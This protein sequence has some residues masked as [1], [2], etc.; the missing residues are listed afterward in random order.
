MLDLERVI[1]DALAIC[2]APS[3]TGSEQARA[4]L[5]TARLAATPGVFPEGDAHGNVLAPIKGTRG[6]GPPVVVAAHL[7][8][9]FGAEVTPRPARSGNRLVGPGIGDNSLALAA[10]LALAAD[11]RTAPPE[12]DVLLVA[13]VGEEGLGNLR[14]IRGLLADR[15]ARFVVALEGHGVDDLV[16]GAVGSTRLE[17][18]CE[19]PGGHS[20]HNRS[21]P[22]AVHELARAVSGLAYGLPPAVPGIAVNIGT[23]SGGTGINVI[24][25]RS[26]FQLDLRAVDAAVLDRGEATARAM[27]AASLAGDGV[28]F[29]IRELGRR[30]AGALGN[31]HPAIGLAQA[32][33]A[34]AGLGPA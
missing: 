3:P 9:V 10:L 24:A 13:T 26:V 23:F 16:T 25:S 17:V 7:D 33:R 11:L 28:S 8:T 31:D 29:S 27:I 14:G 21:A 32:A 19:T 6:G 22:S 1:A 15:S 18:G 30:P 5:I 2:S 4:A 34:A 12:G 20:W